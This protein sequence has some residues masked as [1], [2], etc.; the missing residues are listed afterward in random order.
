MTIKDSAHR[1]T[2]KLFFCVSLNIEMDEFEQEGINEELIEFAIRESIQDDYK[3]PWSIQ[4]DRYDTVQTVYMSNILKVVMAWATYQKYLCNL[5]YNVLMESWMRQP[6][7][8]LFWTSVK[9][10]LEKNLATDVVK[11]TGCYPLFFLGRN[12]TLK[13]T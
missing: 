3:L 9:V 11:L 10:Y 2:E 6:T 13:T 7:L 1:E 5:Y 8:T 4:T 12:Q